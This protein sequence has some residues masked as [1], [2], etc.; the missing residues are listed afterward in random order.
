MSE[1]LKLMSRSPTDRV[2]PELAKGICVRTGG[3]AVLAGSISSLGNEYVVG[4]E[5]VTCNTGDVLAKDQGE[6]TSKEGTL[7]VLSQVT[8]RLRAKLGESLASVQKFEGPV[9]VTTSSLEALKAY[10]IAHTI[11][12]TKGGAEAI[13]FE[14]RA[15]ELDPNFASA[16]LGLGINYL[17]L[18]QEGLAIE[19]ITKAYELRERTSEREQYRISGLYYEVVTGDLQKATE[20]YELWKQIYPDTGPYASLAI[21]HSSFG[22]FEKALSE[23]QEGLR[24]Y[25]DDA[26]GY[27]NVA[28]TYMRLNQLNDARR[29][30]E[31]A[32][33][34]K[35]DNEFLHF[36]SYDLAFLNRDQGEM[37]RQVAW[38]TGKPW[39]EAALLN[40]QSNTEAYYGH[41]RRAREFGRRAVESAIRTDAKEAAARWEVNGALREAKLGNAGAAKHAAISALE[42]DSGKPVKIAA[43]LTLA[44]VGDTARAK[45]LATELEKQYPLDLRLRMFVLPLVEAAIQVNS[46]DAAQ[47]LATLEITLPYEFGPYDVNEVTLYSAYLRGQ[48]ELSSHNGTAAITEFQKLLNHPGVVLNGITGALAHVQLGRAYA[49]QGDTAKAKVAY[50]DFLTLWKDADPDIPILKQ[51]KAEYAKLE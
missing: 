9:E 31:Q 20:V 19:N 50:K 44:Q 14:K 49:M 6:A 28:L 36:R 48:I 11:F 40:R 34:Q 45:K 13:P 32:Q 51:A 21:I 29:M 35:L 2:T 23:F 16:Y 4:L 47:A 30:L 7:K 38:G 3:K 15:I 43:A 17:N 12:N 1:T 10:G 25:P 46:G 33:A 27:S 8:D 26:I 24:V 37:D 18:H 41:L 22:Q 39:A 5:A 42:M